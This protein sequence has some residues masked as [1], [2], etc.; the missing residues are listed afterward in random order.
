MRPAGA[1]HLV[2]PVA[3]PEKRARPAGEDVQQRQRA[4]KAAGQPAAH[5]D[6]LEGLE[7]LLRSGRAGLLQFP[8]DGRGSFPHDCGAYR[9]RY[10]EIPER[11]VA[12]DEGYVR[13]LYLRL[14]LQIKEPIQYGSWSGRTR[15]LTGQDIVIACKAP[16]PV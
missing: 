12:Y 16:L 4:G 11:A 10:R 15:F 3:G 8:F 7:Q 2:R 13:E 14:G 6:V 1:H 9:V 5:G